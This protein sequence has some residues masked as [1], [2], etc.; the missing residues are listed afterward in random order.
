[1]RLLKWLL[2][3]STTQTDTTTKEAKMGSNEV[4]STHFTYDENLETSVGHIEYYRGK[5][6]Y[7]IELAVTHTFP[8]GNKEILCFQFTPG[9]VKDLHQQLQDRYQEWESQNTKREWTDLEKPWGPYRMVIRA[10]ENRGH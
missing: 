9:E 5:S 6:R 8:S 4:N 10:D 7:K 3:G 2:V 1:M